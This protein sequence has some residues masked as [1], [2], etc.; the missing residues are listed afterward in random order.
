M[1]HTAIRWLMA[2]A[3][4][5]AASSPSAILAQRAPGGWMGAAPDDTAQSE[6]TRIPRTEA[7]KVDVPENVPPNTTVIPRGPP[8]AK[9]AASA[10]AVPITLTALLTDVGQSIDQGLVWRVFRD[11]ALPDGKTKLVAT[12]REASPVLHL[13]PGDYLVNV[14]FGRANL[15][16]KITV[17]PGKAATE[18]FV[19]NAGGLRLVAVLAGGEPAPDKSVSYE[20][21]SDERDQFGQRSKILGGAKPGL[22]IRLNAGIYNIVSTYGDANA[23]VRADVT[24]EAGKLTEV[25]VSHAAAKVTFKLVA[26]SGGDAV[27]D[28]QWSIAN[29]QG[30]IIKESV[31]ALPT[32]ILGAGAYTVSA[33]HAGQIFRRDFTVG[34]GENAQVEVVM[35]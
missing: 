11:K 14:A 7:P 30:E 10:L 22:I 29:T 23:I 9:A 19:L 2:G 33:K 4:L 18:K 13:E 35:R 27:A 34:A 16:R 1:S 25:T 32:H 3:W 17:A 20:I 24:V 26:R 5:V 12:H 28:T 31:G 15:T 21:Y 8:E 6:A